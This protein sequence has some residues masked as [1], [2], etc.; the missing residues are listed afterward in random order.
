M[1]FLRRHRGKVHRF[2]VE[3]EPVSIEG[4]SSK[5]AE[6]LAA[7]E[8]D[9]FS[10][11]SLWLV[12]NP[13]WAEIMRDSLSRT[14]RRSHLVGAAYLAVLATGLTSTLR[15]RLRPVLLLQQQGR[16]EV[17]EG[18]Q[19]R[20]GHPAVRV[21]PGPHG[22]DEGEEHGPRAVGG[23]LL[24]GFR[25]CPGRPLREEARRDPTGPAHRTPPVDPTV[26]HH[27]CAGWLFTP[28]RPGQEADRWRPQGSA[29]S[30]RPLAT[31]TEASPRGPW[32]CAPTRPPTPRPRHQPLQP[33]EEP[34]TRVR[35]AG[36]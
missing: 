35:R 17:L 1:A 34:G 21:G 2:E 3:G 36:R 26:G 15:C 33:A 13:G 12:N 5:E 25:R 4:Y 23:R 18:V 19:L 32:R 24:R 20:A 9:R 14:I 27:R 6:R 10:K 28:A 29:R 8:W 22:R 30:G 11:W 7:S 31:E 16:N